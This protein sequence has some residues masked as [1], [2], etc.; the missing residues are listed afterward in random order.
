MAVMA[1]LPAVSAREVFV[2]QSIIS[3]CVV[4]CIISSIFAREKKQRVDASQSFI[5]KLLL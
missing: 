3:T 2:S 5:V 4:N 1:F